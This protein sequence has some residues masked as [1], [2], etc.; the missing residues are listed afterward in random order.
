MKKEQE[1]KEKLPEQT[2]SGSES[3]FKRFEE[4]A[5]KVV[6]TPKPKTK[7]YKYQT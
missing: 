2:E 1:D 5:K 7:K 4:L 6:T 3:P